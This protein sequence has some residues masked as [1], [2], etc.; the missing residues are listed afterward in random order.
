MALKS[1]TNAGLKVDPDAFKGALAWI[2]KMTDPHSGRVGYNFPGGPV[3]RIQGMQDKF[4]PE[5]SQAMTAAGVLGRILC[6]EDPQKSRLIRK[7]ANLMLERRP[8]WDPEAGTIDMYYWYL[9]SLAM[10]QVGGNAWR[11]WG[12]NIDEAIV[13][14]QHRGDGSNAGSW[15]P[16][17]AWG[18]V[19]GRVYSTALMTMCLEVFYRYDKAVKR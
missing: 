11:Q 15:D 7:G 12:A 2:D 6:G 10:F 14:R 3:A 4:P 16:A 13:E 18:T 8:W 9:G 19:G 17:G 5:Q 1:G